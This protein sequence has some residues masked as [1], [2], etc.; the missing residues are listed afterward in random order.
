MEDSSYYDLIKLKTPDG[1]IAA[2]ELG[3]KKNQKKEITYKKG[4][5]S[6]VYSNI[7]FFYWESLPDF[8]QAYGT[9]D[10]IPEL[11]TY[12]WKNETEREP[13]GRKKALQ[14][15]GGM[16]NDAYCTI[17]S[18]ESSKGSKK[19]DIINQAFPVG[20]ELDT[21]RT[22]AEDGLVHVIG[23]EI[24]YSG[25]NGNQLKEE[26]VSRWGESVNVV[27]GGSGT[28]TQPVLSVKITDEAGNSIDYFR[29]GQAVTV[30][31]NLKAVPVPT[32]QTPVYQEEGNYSEGSYSGAGSTGGGY[33]GGGSSAE[34]EPFADFGGTGGDSNGGSPGD[35]VFSD[36][37]FFVE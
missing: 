10:R 28:M 13:S 23:D 5:M 31:L 3:K 24:F 4:K 2:K 34:T 30:T 7:P 27:P 12:L 35:T 32:P 21:S 1:E 17:R 19:G 8:K 22:K 14:E 11:D 26:L 36:G 16:V 37:E 6:I 9:L 29:K 25:K 20:E 15:A 33:S 18:S